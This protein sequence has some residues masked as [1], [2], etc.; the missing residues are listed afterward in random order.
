MLYFAYPTGCVKF[1]FATGYA[2]WVRGFGCALFYCA[3]ILFCGGYVQCMIILKNPVFIDDTQASRMI[4]DIQKLLLK[5]LNDDFT[6]DKKVICSIIDI[7]NEN[8]III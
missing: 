4:K 5:Y 3:K 8:K 7:F 1:C 6:D 2:F